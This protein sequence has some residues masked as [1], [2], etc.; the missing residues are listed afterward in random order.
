MP[1][2]VESIED[3]RLSLRRCALLLKSNSQSGSKDEADERLPSEVVKSGKYGISELP[4]GPC[5]GGVGYGV[6][7][8]IHV[9]SC[10][11]PGLM[12]V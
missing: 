5:P 4:C 8:A 6:E 12:G 3:A 7:W 1:V 10:F 11:V 9:G 2:I